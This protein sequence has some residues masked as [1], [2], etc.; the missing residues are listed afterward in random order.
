[1]VYAAFR[2]MKRDIKLTHYMWSFLG[3]EAVESNE[4]QFI[5]N[6]DQ[7]RSFVTIYMHHNR[8]YIMEGNVPA[9]YPS[10]S[11]FVQSVSLLEQDGAQA[12]HERMFY[13][14]TEVDPTET[15]QFRGPRLQPGNR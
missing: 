14:G 7:S 2:I 5:N 13:N 6:A 8:L 9:D 15:N 11:L 3:Y 12:N 4:L 1:M 10:P